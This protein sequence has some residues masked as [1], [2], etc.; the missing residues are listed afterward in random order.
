MQ[1]M[2]AFL[3]EQFAAMGASVEDLAK[4]KARLEQRDAYYEEWSDLKSWCDGA[5][6]HAL[7][8]APEPPTAKSSPCPEAASIDR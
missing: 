2:I 7:P 1:D 8:R 4:E 6:Q 3:L 5:S